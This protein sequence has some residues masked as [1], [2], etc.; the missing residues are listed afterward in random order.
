MKDVLISGRRIA[1]EIWIFLGCFVLAFAINIYAI[2]EYN[3]QWKE[4]W[5]T[6]PI[7]LAVAVALY[8]LFTILRLILGGV[9]RL[10]RRKTG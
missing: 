9:S 8:V 5:T 1:R 10:F 3:T 6:L 2:H 4:L 7:T